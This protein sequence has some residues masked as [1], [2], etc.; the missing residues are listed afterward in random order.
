MLMG[1]ANEKG[2]ERSRRQE[3]HR[4]WEEESVGYGGSGFAGDRHSLRV[5]GGQV[6]TVGHRDTV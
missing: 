4:R 5:T 3:T 6:D 2:E 1:K